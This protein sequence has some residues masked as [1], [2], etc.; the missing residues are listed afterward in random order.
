MVRLRETGAIA[1]ASRLPEIGAL[2]SGT[3]S[4]RVEETQRVAEQAEREK[5]LLLDADL[6]AGLQGDR[7]KNLL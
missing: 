2:D 7:V 6:L 5:A 4:M 3:S 1:T